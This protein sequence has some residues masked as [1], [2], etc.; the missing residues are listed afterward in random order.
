MYFCWTVY[1]S[2]KH[3]S[4]YPLLRG[5]SLRNQVLL[6][7]VEESRDFTLIVFNTLFVKEISLKFLILLDSLLVSQI[8]QLMKTQCSVSRSSVVSYIGEE[9]Q[10]HSRVSTGIL[11]YSSSLPKQ[12]TKCPATHSPTQGST[13]EHLVKTCAIQSLK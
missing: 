4:H 12:S 11:K 9:N 5:K 3:H 2:Q 13:R 10:L 1:G 6:D 8:Y 7:I